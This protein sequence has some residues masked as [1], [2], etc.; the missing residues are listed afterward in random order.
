MSQ[1]TL[2]S[3]QRQEGGVS[4]VGLYN[5][6]NQPGGSSSFPL[7][8]ALSQTSYLSSAS[9]TSV[10]NM[11]TPRHTQHTGWPNPLPQVKH[12]VVRDK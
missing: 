1:P 12:I 5:G 2:K 8:D 10:Q 7:Y 9:S 11:T 3:K 6:S 4:T